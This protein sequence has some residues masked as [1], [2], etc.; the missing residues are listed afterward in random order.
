MILKRKLIYT[1]DGLAAFAVGSFGCPQVVWATAELGVVAGIAFA[2]ATS[3][4]AAGS[5]RFALEA[6][7]VVRAGSWSHLIRATAVPTSDAMKYKTNQ[8]NY[9]I[10]ILYSDSLQATAI[11]SSSGEAVVGGGSVVGSGHPSLS[12]PSDGVNSSGQ[13]PNREVLQASVKHPSLSSPMAGV[14]PSGQHLNSAS[15]HVSNLGHPIIN[16]P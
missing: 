7:L 5:I 14:T 9:R 12:L 6:S 8:T 16:G 3:V 11:N 15:W 2:S 13:Q 10:I 4:T 1:F